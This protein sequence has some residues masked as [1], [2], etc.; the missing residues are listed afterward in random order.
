MI[1]AAEHKIFGEQR[2]FIWSKGPRFSGPALFVN[3]NPVDIRSHTSDAFHSKL[4]TN[5][6]KMAKYLADRLPLG[7]PRREI[8]N[9]LDP[10]LIT[11]MT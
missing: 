10:A 2:Q 7:G 11:F 8:P 3:S 1:A 6:L 5:Y 9:D 4:M